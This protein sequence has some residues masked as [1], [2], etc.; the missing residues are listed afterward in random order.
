MVTAGEV[1]AG[2]PTAS[3]AAGSSQKNYC[4]DPAQLDPVALHRLERRRIEPAT[5]RR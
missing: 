2:V 3:P 4:F 5:C 1:V